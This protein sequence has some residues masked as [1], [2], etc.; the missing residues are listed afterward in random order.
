MKASLPDVAKLQDDAGGQLTLYVQIPV[1]DL[2]AFGIR[3][4]MAVAQRV[5]GQGRKAAGWE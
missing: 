3:L 1:L 4:D 2:R 5:F